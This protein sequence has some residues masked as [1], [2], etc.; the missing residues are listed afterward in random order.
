MFL[1]PAELRDLTKRQHA[2]AQIAML[3][4][5]GWP[6]VLDGDGRPQVARVV[7]EARIW[8]RDKPPAAVRK[9]SKP[10]LDLVR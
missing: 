2:D 4:R 6:Y 3:E 7:Y 1:T 9:T 5:H 10:R 8:G